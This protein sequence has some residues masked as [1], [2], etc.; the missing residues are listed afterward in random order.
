MAREL[1]HTNATAVRHLL[2]QDWD[3][4]TLESQCSRLYY[5]PPV[6]MFSNF[7]LDDELSP[8]QIAEYGLQDK[9]RYNVMKTLIQSGA[10]RLREI[11]E[12]SLQPHAT[13]ALD[14]L[15][16]SKSPGVDFPNF[17]GG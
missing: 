16:K 8:P 2:T 9:Q 14:N 11:L 5:I 17:R 15:V 1:S 12:L 13:L 10:I 7:K 3:D 4:D 6:G